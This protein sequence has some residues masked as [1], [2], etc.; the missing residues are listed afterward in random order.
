MNI[1]GILVGAMSFLAIGIF[2][3]I[4]IKCEYYFSSKIWPLFLA[5]GLVFLTLSVFVED[6]TLSSII[7]VFGFSMLWSILELKHQEKRV[8]K[9]W[10]PA[11]PKRKKK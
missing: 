5:G 4:V 3:P 2:H 11:N 10:F 7:A 6:Q 8:E 9:G 1:N